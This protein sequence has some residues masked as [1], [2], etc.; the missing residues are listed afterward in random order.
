MQKVNINDVPLDL[1]FKYFEKDD[2]ENKVLQPKLVDKLVTVYAYNFTVNST[3][4]RFYT[5]NN[6]SASVITDIRRFFADIIPNIE[7]ATITLSLFSTQQNQYI[8]QLKNQE[9]GN[10]RLVLPYQYSFLY[11]NGTYRDFVEIDEEGGEINLVDLRRPISGGNFFIIESDITLESPNSTYPFTV[12]D[13]LGNVIGTLYNNEKFQTQKI[14]TV[15]GQ[16]KYVYID[17]NGNETYN[18][19]EKS[20]FLAHNNLLRVGFNGL[21]R[22]DD[23]LTFRFNPACIGIVKDTAGERLSFYET[24]TITKTI[25]K[26]PFNST[27]EFQ[28]DEIDS[29]LKE[30]LETLSRKTKTTVEIKKIVKDVANLSSLKRIKALATGLEDTLSQFNFLFKQ[31]Y[32]ETSLSIGENIYVKEFV[33]IA[34]FNNKRF[35]VFRPSN[36]VRNSDNNV[37]GILSYDESNIPFIR[38]SNIFLVNGRERITLD[39]NVLDVLYE[40]TSNPGYF[41]VN[42]N[43]RRYKLQGEGTNRFLPIQCITE[44]EETGNEY[45]GNLR[46]FKDNGDIILGKYIFNAS[47]I[48]IQDEFDLVGFTESRGT[49]SKKQRTQDIYD[50]SYCIEITEQIKKNTSSS[51]ISLKEFLD[52]K[53][54]KVES[55]QRFTLQNGIKV[56]RDE[57][58]NSAIF[59][60]SFKEN[61]SEFNHY[62]SLGFLQYRGNVVPGD[63]LTNMKK[64]ALIEMSEEFVAKKFDNFFVVNPT[65]KGI[66]TLT[67]M[68]V[69]SDGF[70]NLIDRDSRFDLDFVSTK[71]II[72]PN[73]FKQNI[74]TEELTGF[75]KSSDSDLEIEKY[76]TS[77]QFVQ[78][79]LG[80]NS[81]Q[82]L[83]EYDR[84]PYNE[85][86][87]KYYT[88]LYRRFL[89]YRDKKNSIGVLEDI[90]L[91]LEKDLTT[92]TARTEFREGM[93]NNFINNF[94][95]VNSYSVLNGTK[96]LENYNIF[97]KDKLDILSPIYIYNILVETTE[98]KRYSK[99]YIDSS[100]RRELVINILSKDKNWRVV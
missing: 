29:L 31:T 52:Y 63:V 15:S 72:K 84:F 2:L 95:E 10:I 11:N 54:S 44:Y 48:K 88:E 6:D 89:A 33:E 18:R 46:G 39:T 51:S 19:L 30:E 17:P 16:K 75:I 97:Y 1:F 71:S 41:Y 61:F 58:I 86:R 78:A 12:K 38:F 69:I 68:R 73:E 96:F 32:P 5:I 53:H 91:S 81:F 36:E 87:E 45:I 56:K 100:T 62:E 24:F 67:K 76:D 43:N 13:S 49:Y 90:E 57:A 26:I 8:F 92:L 79:Q 3:N 4:Y 65:S 59:V 42:M 50:R 40:G 27:L 66:N 83:I 20:N 74:D 64:E 7:T 60:Q 9:T 21:L 77:G 14:E 47:N 28:Q 99:D 82:K 93:I 55:G 35:R 80:L 23:S 34:V 70:K 25:K 94:Y 98:K 85:K 37:I 22:P